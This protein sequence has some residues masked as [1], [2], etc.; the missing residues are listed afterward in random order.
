MSSDRPSGQSRVRVTIREV[1][2]IVVGV[3]I[4][5]TLEARW[6]MILERRAENDLIDRLRVELSRNA[7]SVS[8]WLTLHERVAASTAELIHVLEDVPP[9]SRAMVAD[10][11]LGNMTRT[12][13]YDPEQGSLD[14]AVSS[15]QLSLI[16]SADIQRALAALG[17]SLRDAQEDEAQGAAHVQDRLLPHLSEVTDLGPAVAW[18]VQDVDAVF[19]GEPTPA[20]PL[21]A[22]SVVASEEL[23]NL[24]WLQLRYSSDAMNGLRAYLDDLNE[25][26]AL[27]G[28]GQGLG[29][30]HP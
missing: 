1:V 13:T 5:L 27:M 25:A 7:E 20:T 2:L 14:A 26:V 12:P 21:G 17:R 22:R 9:G 18:V 4:A 6:Q 19:S 3:M 15:G 29:G 11:L 8:R 30:P 16:R 10:S 24:L 23:S 28:P